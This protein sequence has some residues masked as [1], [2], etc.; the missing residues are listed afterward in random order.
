ML[1]CK[2][3][4]PKGDVLKDRVKGQ[5]GVRLYQQMG[6]LKIEVSDLDW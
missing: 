4:Y 2:L 1:R 5:E 3:R 6:R